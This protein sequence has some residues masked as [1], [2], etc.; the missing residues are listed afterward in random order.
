MEMK[1]SIWMILGLLRQVKSVNGTKEAMV[2]HLLK[3][4]NALKKGK[5]VAWELKAGKGASNDNGT[6]GDDESS[7]TETSQPLKRK[8]LEVYTQTTLKYLKGPDIPFTEVQKEAIKSQFGCATASANLPFCW[9]DDPE[10]I[11]LFM[12]FRSPEQCELAGWILNEEYKKV[13]EEL[14]EC[15]L[16]LGDYFKENKEAAG[17]AEDASN[18]LGWI[19]NHTKVHAIFD[20]TQL[21]KNPALTKLCAYKTTNLTRWTTHFGSFDCLGDLKDPLQHAAFLKQQLVIDVQVGAE[22]NSQKKQEMTDSANAQCDLIL[23]LA[24]WKSLRSIVDDIKPICYAV[25]ICQSDKVC[26]DQ[27]LLTLGGLFLHFSCHENHVVHEGMR[28][29]LEKCWKSYDR[30]LGP[31]QFGP[32]WS[33][34]RSSTNMSNPALHHLDS[35]KQNLLSSMPSKSKKKIMCLRLLLSI[36]PVLGIFVTGKKIKVQS[37]PPLSKDHQDLA[38]QLTQAVTSPENDKGPSQIS[39][40]AGESLLAIPQYKTLTDDSVEAGENTPGTGS[41]Y[42]ASCAGWQDEV[43]DLEIEM[44]I[45]DLTDGGPNSQLSWPINHRWLP[46]TLKKLFGGTPT[47]P[48]DD[49][50]GVQ[51]QC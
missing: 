39:L 34:S 45:D 11:A 26:L 33:T 15:Q 41:V 10:V 3:C 24:F 48:L 36:W 5:K 46:I 22:K 43:E 4:P 2:L 31:F 30:M 13:E 25:N 40:P 38:A 47:Q 9:V 51:T 50:M 37:K 17:Y 14:K 44:E 21:E 8:K 7:D 27:V 20:E 42:V 16:I 18:L 29:H 35:P 1:F 12:M 32:Y 28:K 6:D 19:L 23:N 49:F